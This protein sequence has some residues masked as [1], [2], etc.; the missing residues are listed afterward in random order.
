[1]SETG[2]QVVED[3]TSVVVLN[4]N[5]E[6]DLLG[7]GDIE[8]PEEESFDDEDSLSSED[9]NDVIDTGAINKAPY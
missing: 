1:M 5:P 9:C 4:L 6:I 7:V 8:L 3:A 2:K